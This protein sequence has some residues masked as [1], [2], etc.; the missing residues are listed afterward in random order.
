MFQR[1]TVIRPFV[2]ENLAGGFHLAAVAHQHVPKI[3]ADL[4]AKVA[5]QRAIGLVHDGAALLALGV[6]GF[7]DRKRDQAVVVGRH[8]ARSVDMRR[9]R[10]EIE[11]QAM[12]IAVFL[13]KRQ[14]ELHQ[15]VEQ[16]MLGD[17]DLAPSDDVARDRGVRNHPVVPAGV[18][19]IVGRIRLDQ[20]VAAAADRDL[21][22]GA[23]KRYCL[24]SSAS[25]R[26]SLASGSSADRFMISEIKPRRRAHFS[27]TVFS[28]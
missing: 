22:A 8:H 17:L 11:H 6:V 13:A 27:Q 10:Q 12:V 18:A 5:K 26:H 2:A 7:L 20:P 21:P 9:A 1:L 24:S 15:C 3:M 16:P 28:K 23:Q 4:V 14:V 19:K 25:A